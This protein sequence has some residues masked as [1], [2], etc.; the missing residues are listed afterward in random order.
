M[1]EVIVCRKFPIPSHSIATGSSPVV[2]HGGD[3]V[4]GLKDEGL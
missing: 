4:V 2:F 3:D 1:R